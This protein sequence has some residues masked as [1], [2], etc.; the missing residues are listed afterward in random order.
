MGILKNRRDS[1]LR[2]LVPPAFFDDEEDEEE[3]EIKCS[4][5]LNPLISGG[6]DAEGKL[7][8]F[9]ICTTVHKLSIGKKL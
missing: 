2:P 3:E 9:F 4:L 5:N 6:R 7:S 8:F 1:R